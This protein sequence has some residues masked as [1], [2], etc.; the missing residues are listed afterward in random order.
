MIRF[1]IL[2]LR[3]TFGSI[4]I[5]FF[6]NSCLWDIFLEFQALCYLSERPCW[7]DSF[8]RNQVLSYP[9][10]VLSPASWMACI[11]SVSTSSQEGLCLCLCRIWGDQTRPLVAVAFRFMIIQIQQH[12]CSDSSS[13]RWQDSDN[14]QPSQCSFPCYL[15]D[16]FIYQSLP[17]LRIYYLSK[18]SSF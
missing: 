18:N 4:T 15:N 10:D 16:G 9:T 2:P 1:F 11:P 14:F 5:R 17:C 13:W 7:L 3:L 12:W 8:L 6:N